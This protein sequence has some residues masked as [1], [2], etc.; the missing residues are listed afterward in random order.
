MMLDNL[1]STESVLLASVFILE[2]GAGFWFLKWLKTPGRTEQY[3]LTARQRIRCYFLILLMLL[4]LVL[5][6]TLGGILSHFD[7]PWY[8][9]QGLNSN[10]WVLSKAHYYIFLICYPAYLIF[11]RAIYI[12]LNNWL[13]ELLPKLKKATLISSVIPFTFIP[14]V[15]GNL[16]D[17]NITFF[18][19]VYIAFYWV[20]NLVWLAMGII[21]I[22]YTMLKG[23][24]NDLGQSPT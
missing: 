16:L 13:T 24:V 21:P 19:S 1:G 5:S 11:G 2:I 23:L 17:L 18:E 6:V 12:L 15:D 4:L 3:N 20:A 14:A 22:T 8:A 9:V 7:R 10:Q